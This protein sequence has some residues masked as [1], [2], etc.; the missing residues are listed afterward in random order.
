MSQHVAYSNMQSVMIGTAMTHLLGAM[1]SSLPLKERE[2]LGTTIVDSLT[3]LYI[4][5]F[6]DRYRASRD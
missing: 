5:G 4:K 6:T 3:N 2:R 1:K